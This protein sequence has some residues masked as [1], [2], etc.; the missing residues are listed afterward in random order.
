MDNKG[1]FQLVIK[2][3]DKLIAEKSATNVNSNEYGNYSVNY[4]VRFDDEKIRDEYYGV[5]VYKD[6][7]R[8]WNSDSFTMKIELTEEYMIE[9]KYKLNQLIKISEDEAIEFL[10]EF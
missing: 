10:K 4:V 1:K 3:L 2:F 7:L 9:F 8:F 6:T 5:S